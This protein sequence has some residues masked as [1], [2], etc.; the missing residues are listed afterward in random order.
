ML[1]VKLTVMVPGEPIVLDGEIGN[2]SN[3]AAISSYE[4]RLEGR[5]TVTLEGYPR[6]SEPVQGLLA[7]CI[8]LSKANAEQTDEVRLPSNWKSVRVDI[9]LNSGGRSRRIERLAMCRVERQDGNICTVGSREATLIRFFECLDLRPNYDDV[10]D[11]AHHALCVSTFGDDVLLP[12]K[13]LDVPIH[14]EPGYS[15]VL[16]HEIPEPLR[17]AFEYRQRWSG[18][19]CVPRGAHWS[20]DYLDFVNGQR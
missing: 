7:R 18:R 20:W 15:Y 11:V 16:S 19:P 5:K 13:P 4:A 9:G 3:L 2:V 17:S 14:E 1:V 8:A 6:W 10:W 12:T